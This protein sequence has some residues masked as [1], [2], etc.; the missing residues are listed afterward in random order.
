M[1]N[2]IIC[3]TSKNGDILR[4][5]HEQYCNGIELIGAGNHPNINWYKDL[6]KI[7]L[8]SGEFSEEFLINI[9]I[10]KTLAESHNDDM[11]RKSVESWLNNLDFT[12]Y[13]PST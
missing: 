7:T 9:K 12:I 8:S 5:Y 6:N 13:R 11:T 3:A 2:F 4:I 10:V 1:E